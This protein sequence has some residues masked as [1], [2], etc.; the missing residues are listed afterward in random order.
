MDILNFGKYRYEENTISLIV[1]FDGANYTKSNKSS[2]WAMF[3]IIAELPPI[4]RYA[5]SNILS[6]FIISSSQADIN[7]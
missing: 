4:V 1:F 7:K 5:Y 6:H 2:F 3:S